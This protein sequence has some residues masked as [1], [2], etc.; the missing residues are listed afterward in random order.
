MGQVQHLINDPGL[1]RSVTQ[2][3]E[4]PMVTLEHSTF[5]YVIYRLETID[6][7][8]GYRITRVNK[9]SSTHTNIEEAFLLESSRLSGA[10]GSV[11]DVSLKLDTA[12]LLLLLTNVELIYD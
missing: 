10:N 5:T 7:V 3:N 12:N 9:V 2:Q 8:Q 11:V 6:Q 4:K 1:T